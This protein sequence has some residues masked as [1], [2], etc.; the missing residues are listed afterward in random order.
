MLKGSV[1]VSDC[2]GLVGN[3]IRAFEV[4]NESDF[5]IDLINQSIFPT[6]LY[7]H[8]N[9]YNQIHPIDDEPIVKFILDRLQIPARSAEFYFKETK[10]RDRFSGLEEQIRYNNGRRK[11]R[12][13]NYAEIL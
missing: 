11:R 5:P 2:L 4:R 7:S 12:Q 10:Y 9:S 6:P 8:I 13:V 1:L 3:Y